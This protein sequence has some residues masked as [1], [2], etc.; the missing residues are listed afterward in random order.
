MQDVG[1]TST[2]KITVLA[3]N[4]SLCSPNSVDKEQMT[5]TDKRFRELID[6]S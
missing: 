6:A 1:E 3:A 4:S 2:E 5:S